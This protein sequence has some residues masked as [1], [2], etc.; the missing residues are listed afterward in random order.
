LSATSAI[1]EWNS[2]K[3]IIPLEDDAYLTATGYEWFR[4][5]QTGWYLIR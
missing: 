3:L 4:P 2:Q 5:P 1:P